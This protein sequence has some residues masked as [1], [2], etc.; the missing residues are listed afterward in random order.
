MGTMSDTYEHSK[1]G[2]S[3]F[4]TALNSTT[5]R[6]EIQDTNGHEPP[7][8]T[9]RLDALTYACCAAARY[10]SCFS[11]K[12]ASTIIAVYRLKVKTQMNGNRGWLDA[13]R[14][15]AT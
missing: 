10:V 8:P 6:A 14:P 9:Y 5:C 11:E 3:S 4:C 12:H 13:S 15:E 7:V 1:L 2:A